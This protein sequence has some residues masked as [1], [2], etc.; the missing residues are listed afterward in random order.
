G[1]TARI[2]ITA[3]EPA[4]RDTLKG[5][6]MAALLDR[7][8]L[9]NQPNARADV[10]RRSGEVLSQGQEAR[11]ILMARLGTAQ[12]QI[13]QAEQRN[14]AE[15]SALGIARSELLA[16]DGYEAGSRLQ[17]AQTQLETLYALTSRMSRLSLVNFL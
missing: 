15:T 5:L 1:E 11:G 4:I 10:V 2:D 3:A 16:V 9:A 12:F 6:A 8:L 13:E 7:G 14:M 17:E